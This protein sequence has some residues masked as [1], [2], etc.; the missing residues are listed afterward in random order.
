MHQ[1]L[2]YEVYSAEHMVRP[3]A[4]SIFSNRQKAFN[5]GVYWLALRA[6]DVKCGANRRFPVTLAN[7]TR[8]NNGTFY[9]RWV[10]GSRGLQLNVRLIPW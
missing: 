1:P 4:Q 2:P 10:H 5:A 3:L 8:Y 6:P 7:E 9:L